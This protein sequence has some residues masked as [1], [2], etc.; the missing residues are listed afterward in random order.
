MGIKSHMYCGKFLMSFYIYKA[1]CLPGGDREQVW[2]EYLSS[3]TL[4]DKPS[5]LIVAGSRLWFYH[6]YN[7]KIGK[8]T[9]YIPLQIHNVD[10]KHNSQSLGFDIN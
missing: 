10:Q 3:C 6:L 1:P 4:R 2:Y 9:E 7:G 5:R 8:K